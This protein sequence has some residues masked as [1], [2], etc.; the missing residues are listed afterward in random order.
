MIKLPHKHRSIKTI[1]VLTWYEQFC[2][3]HVCLS[4]YRGGFDP[5]ANQKYYF[6]PSIL[7]R[8]TIKLFCRQLRGQYT[9]ISEVC[10]L[11]NWIFLA[12]KVRKEPKKQLFGP[13]FRK[14]ACCA[15]FFGQKG[16][17]YCVLGVLGKSVWLTLKK[18][19][20]FFKNLLKITSQPPPP[21]LKN[22]RNSQENHNY[23]SQIG[24]TLG[25]NIWTQ[26]LLKVLAK[27]IVQFVLRKSV[28]KFCLKYR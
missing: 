21:P 2:L 3:V 9:L 13:V 25:E 10:T 4:R 8:P 14:F 12:K 11:K 15:T 18:V 23:F 22:T 1:R 19:D 28:P 27:K 16:G 26:N 6:M 24:L 7:G 20:K 17:L 5:L